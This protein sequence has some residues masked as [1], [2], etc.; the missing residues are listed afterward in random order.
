MISPYHNLDIY[1]QIGFFL[2]FSI[3]FVKIKASM[4]GLLIHASSHIILVKNLLCWAH[5]CTGLIWPK[6]T[7]GSEPTSNYWSIT[8][9][10]RRAGRKPTRGTP[11]NWGQL[12]SHYSSDEM[13]RNKWGTNP[14]APT[15]VASTNQDTGG[16]WP[17]GLYKVH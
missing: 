16:P 2:P 12:A 8:R 10:K 5:S 1:A 9:I 3:L 17:W 14:K 13:E 11:G 4:S 6:W 15:P 7:W